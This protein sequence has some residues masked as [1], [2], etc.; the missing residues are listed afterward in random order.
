LYKCEASPQF[1]SWHQ[2]GNWWLT[3][4]TWQ[5]KT[6]KPSSSIETRI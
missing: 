5:R 2:P 3:H 4:S 1:G 6:W